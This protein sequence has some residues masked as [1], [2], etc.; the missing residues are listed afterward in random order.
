MPVAFGLGFQNNFHLLSVNRWQPWELGVK[1]PMHQPSFALWCWAF[2]NAH[3]RF[4][5]LHTESRM[6]L[7]SSVIAVASER[8]LRSR[9]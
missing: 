9:K 6:G 7:V 1:A 4:L 3:F 5:A 8:D 2:W